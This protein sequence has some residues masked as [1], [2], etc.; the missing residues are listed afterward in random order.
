MIYSLIGVAFELAQ[1]CQGAQVG[2]T[3]TLVNLGAL[4]ETVYLFSGASL[5][6]SSK[7]RFDLVL[8]VETVQHIEGDPALVCPLGVGV[9]LVPI[10]RESCYRTEPDGGEHLVLRPQRPP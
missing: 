5:V 9:S 6:P 3:I 8:E 1:E 2:Y 4:G 7:Q 10:P